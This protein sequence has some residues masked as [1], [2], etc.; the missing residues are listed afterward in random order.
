[1]SEVTAIFLDDGGVIND[2]NLRGPE[3]RRLVADFF[4]PLLGGDRRSWMEA[5]LAVFE[6]LEP[7]LIEG[8]KGQNYSEWLDSF[9]LAW[10]REMTGHV[11]VDGPANDVDCIELAWQ[12]SD[13]ITS[14]VRS[15]Y[16][17]VDVAIRD[18]S[19]MGFKLFTAS[20]EHSRELAGY[21]DGIGVREYFSC[22]YG[23]DLINTGKVSVDYYRRI[24]A[25][26]DIRPECA[27]VVDD[28]LHNLDWAASLGATTCL[29]S[30][31]S[32]CKAKADFVAG[33]LEH[34]VSV[35][36]TM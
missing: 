33:S 32:H 20:A 13:Y 7:M 21:L 28:R 8:P 29:I 17:G 36:H 16:L 27:L 12:A 9:Q 34:L 2:N 15:S 1:M 19:R 5:N 30:S 11:G 35:L 31:D 25:H 4:M 23:P 18:I 26:A 14:R 22:L 24:F 6:R 3:W 10:L